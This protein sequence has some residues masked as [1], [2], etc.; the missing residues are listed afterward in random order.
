MGS[1]TA[2]QAPPLLFLQVLGEPREAALL[3]LLD[4]LDRLAVGR[5][6]L[7]AH[8]ANLLAPVIEAMAEAFHER[9]ERRL[10]PF[11]RRDLRLREAVLP[12]DPDLDVQPRRARA[13]FDRDPVAFEHRSEE[14]TSEL[15][16]H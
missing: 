7:E 1:S 11:A 6:R 12:V 2:E 10:K 9:V 4:D 8:V 13:I 3:E 15:Q 16:S 5:L 14:H